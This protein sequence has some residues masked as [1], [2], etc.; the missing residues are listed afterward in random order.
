MSCRVSAVAEAAKFASKD[1]FAGTPGYASPELMMSQTP[2]YKTDVWACG[3][4]LYNM[5]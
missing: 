5:W 2:D 1:H 3:V 4:I